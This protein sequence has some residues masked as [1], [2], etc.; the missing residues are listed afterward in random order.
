MIGGIPLEEKEMKRFLL[1]VFLMASV[2]FVVFAGG[3]QEASG[4]QAATATQSGK[5]ITHLRFMYYADGNEVKVLTPILDRFKAKNPGI[6]VNFDVVPYKTIDQQLP[7]QVQAGQGPDLA[8]ITNFGTYSG[9]YLDLRKYMSNPS[10]YENNFPKPILKAME[11]GG[12]PDR[13]DVTAPFVNKTLFDQA[14]IALPGP[15]ATWPDWTK[16]AEEV[17][18]K[19]GVPYAISI[20][21]T[22]AR[23][24]GPA[25]TMG[26]TLVSDNG[27]ITVDSPGFRAFAKL[28]KSWFTDKITPS[29]VWLVGNGVNSCIQHF[30][31]GDLVM[32]YSGSWQIST[33]SKNV[34]TKFD[35]IVVPNPS[36]AGGSTGV[37]G[38]SAV[39]AFKQ[40]KHPDA[41][42]KLVSY[43]IQPDNYA[44]FSAGT[45]NL[46]AETA[47]AKKGV[48]YKA[49]DPA[50]VSALKVF[51]AEI[52]KLQPQALG[53]NVSP[54]AF[55]YY[56]STATRME[57]YITGGLSLSEALSR[58]Q[59]NINAAE[60]AAKK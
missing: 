34:G 40:T 36:G 6:D 1:T 32:C 20:D 45:L 25:M 42:A 8:R 57:Q 23:F 27:K 2:A 48:D 28:F 56:R 30:E 22:G 39:A 7:V 33:L 11:Y 26:A 35:W 43:L 21:R 58:I 52:P 59:Q 47:V 55:A 51:T 41:V 50:I 18:K 37:A 38:G 13:L 54:Y 17:A 60:T 12:F 3:K 49:S 24:A 16:V 31:S 4:N 14:G 10:F 53:L 15:K 29:D 19:T 44:E 9:E 46:P 5:S